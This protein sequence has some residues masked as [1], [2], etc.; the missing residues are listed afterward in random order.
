MVRSDQNL[1]ETEG[2]AIG[3]SDRLLAEAVRAIERDGAAAIDEPSADARA[4]EVDGDFEHRLVVRAR[5]LSIVGELR[6][7]LRRSRQVLIW[8]VVIGLVLAAAAGGGAARAA[9]ADQPV[10]VFWALGGLLGIQTLLLFAWV[11]MM[12]KRPAGL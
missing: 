12:V 9:L 3:F 10:N 1:P 4:L 8:I 11:V 7:A 6:P 5:S 2:G